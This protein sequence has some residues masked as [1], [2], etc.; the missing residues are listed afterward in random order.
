METAVEVS[1]GATLIETESARISDT[2]DSLVL[3]THSDEFARPCGR[4]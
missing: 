3:N 2:K 1:G 4:S